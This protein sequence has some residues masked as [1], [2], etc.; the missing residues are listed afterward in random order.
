[1]YNN[2]NNYNLFENSFQFSH[3]IKVLVVA[4]SP[5]AYI[6]R[7]TPEVSSHDAPSGQFPEEIPEQINAQYLSP[8]EV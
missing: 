8:V 3:K 4:I 5:E 2:I 6:Q 7:P 1:M